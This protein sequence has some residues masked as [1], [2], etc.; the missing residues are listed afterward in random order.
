MLKSWGVVRLFLVDV[1]V[2]EV[3]SGMSLMAWR[4][5]WKCLCSV[6]EVF[7]VFLRCFRCLG[8]LGK[9]LIVCYGSESRKSIQT[10]SRMIFQNNPCHSQKQQ[11]PYLSFEKGIP[12]SPP[13]SSE[14]RNETSPY[15]GFQGKVLLKANLRTFK[16]RP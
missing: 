14:A 8:C 10:H 11:I 1:K 2:F 7:L 16:L 13:T 15:Q 5:F 3:F 9:C 4:C 6:L 12:V